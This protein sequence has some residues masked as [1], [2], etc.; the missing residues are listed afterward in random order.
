MWCQQCDTKQIQET[1]R[2][3]TRRSSAQEVKG[4]DQVQETKSK[5]NQKKQR[6]SY[7]AGR[8]KGSERE[9]EEEKQRSPMPKECDAYREEESPK[10][11][12]TSVAK[13]VYRNISSLK[14]ITRDNQAESKSPGGDTCHGLPRDR[15]RS[16]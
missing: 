9:T 14:Q 12:K 4:Q 1:K 13:T 6:R 2:K 5:K 15:G 8:E 3:K 7:E 16:R 11:S 10:P